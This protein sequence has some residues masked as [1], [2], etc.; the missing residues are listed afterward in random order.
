MYIQPF[1]RKQ[2]NGSGAYKIPKTKLVHQRLSIVIH[3]QFP[4][5]RKCVK[6]GICLNNLVPY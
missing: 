3:V 5:Q 4:L 6:G 2:Q 1:R